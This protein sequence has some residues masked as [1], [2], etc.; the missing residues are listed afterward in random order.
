MEI[1]LNE[2]IEQIK[3]NGV[4]EAESEAKAIIEAARA[5]ATK[6]VADAEA[7]AEALLA[8]AKTENDRM[9]RVSEDAI[10]QAGRNLLLSF[11]ES[12][13]R[14]LDAVVNTEVTAAYSEDKLPA[15]I[16]DVVKAWSANGQSEDITVLLN[17]QALASLEGALRD[18]LRTRMLDG[19]T[20][21]ASN[22]FDG[23]FRIAV[24]EGRVYY[25]YSAEAV[26]EMLSAYLNPRVTALM[27]E[28]HT[29]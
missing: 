5:E 4:E 16:A 24:K 11:R 27:K 9:V 12:V 23:G 15:L 21:A 8:K 29:V 13:T 7:E 25:D 28:A 20:L 17:E 14:E 1:Q 6:I 26:T 18:A 3:K 2:L 10:R 19:V 22:S